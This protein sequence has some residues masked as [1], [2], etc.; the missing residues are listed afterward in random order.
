M[1]LARVLKSSFF[2][3]RK[4]KLY[5]SFMGKSDPPPLPPGSIWFLTR[6]P[7][8]GRGVGSTLFTCHL[9]FDASSALIAG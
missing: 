5:R 9:E 1:K 4:A 3:E 6:V 8:G 2:F 7:F